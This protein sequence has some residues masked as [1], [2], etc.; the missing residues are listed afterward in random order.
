MSRVMTAKDIG[1]RALRAIG[2]W[3]TTESA[4]D[5]ENLRE[6]MI[7]LDM[8]MAEI[9]GTER[10]FSRVTPSM[11]TFALVNGT[12][13]Y[14]FNATLGAALPAD[15]I[16]FLVDAWL[17]DASGNRYSI[18][19]V[20]REKFENVAKPADTGRPIWIYLDLAGQPTAP[21]LRIFPT[22]DATDPTVWSLKLV[23]QTY[24]PNVAPSGVTGTIPQSTVLHQ[25]GQAWQRFLTAQLAHDLGAGPIFKLPEASLTRFSAMAVGS[26]T[27]LL[28][29]NNREHET[30]PCVGESA[31]DFDSGASHDR[32][33]GSSDYGNRRPY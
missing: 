9:A 13:S 1:C 7:W 16:E 12:S 19:I 27:R 33:G 18:E 17:E 15:G 23:G 22:P 14:D 21:L 11:L 8:I 24:A 6:A 32:M 30:T 10:L 3:P 20:N 4:P 28:A 2:A 5:G 31:W 26:K 29:F 25:F